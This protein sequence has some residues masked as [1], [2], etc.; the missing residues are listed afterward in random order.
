MRKQTK[1]AVVLSAA[2]LFVVGASMTSFASEWKVD[3]NGLWYY[4]DNQGNYVTDTWKKYGNNSYYLGSDGYMLTNQL[5][6]DG[7]NYY[8]VDGDGAMVKNGW[9]MVE[10]DDTDADLDVEYRWYYFGSTG[11]A[12]K[13][14]FKKSIN[15]KN[16]GFDADGKMLFGFVDDQKTIQTINEDEAP[17]YSLYY[18]N[19]NT[20]GSMYT[21]WLEYEQGVTN[22]DQYEDKDQIW[23][24]YNPTNGKKIYSATAGAYTTKTV[25]SKKYAFDS[26][27]VMLSKWSDGATVGSSTTQ[28]YFSDDTEGWQ[29]KKG[30]FYAVP[31][32][33]MVAKITKGG[34]TGDYD[35]DQ[36]RW[37]YANSNGSLVIDGTKRINSKW[38]VFD[39]I[40]R[41]KN[42]LIVMDS[43]KIANAKMVKRLGTDDY[44]GEDLRKV[45]FL[46]AG[47][48][49]Y[50]FSSSDSDG[51]AKTGSIKIEMSDEPYTFCFNKSTY[52]GY[53]KVYSNKLYVNGVLISA[54]DMK[55]G[56]GK[57]SDGKYYVV[58]N[59]G[60][61]LAAKKYVK[62]ADDNYYAVNAAKE[63]AYIPAADEASAIA[64][65]YATGAATWSYGTGSNKISGTTASSVQTSG[66]SVINE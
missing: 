13:D 61:V 66:F 43:D 8:Y 25:K 40:G 56:V 51:S 6:E 30:W 44:A 20:D 10:A 64:K 53:N 5:I 50:Y 49:L 7:S 11:K 17:L 42:G 32:E 65:A 52:V 28:M 27:G 63:I 57:G 2:A 9:R 55:Y 14:N 3:E 33:D 34:N 4:H 15:G 54:G 16:Y 58:N 19:D 59:S 22:I 23:F 38:Y 29:S 60:T 45:D 48:Y 21:G 39:E 41:M 36:K 18:Y 26:N 31:S 47:Q 12:Y 46:S 1:L 37:F 24:Y 62:D 35:D